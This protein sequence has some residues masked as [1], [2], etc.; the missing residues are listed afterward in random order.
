MLRKVELF[1]E[2]KIEVF[3]WGKTVEG[4]CPSCK[5]WFIITDNNSGWFDI[6]CPCCETELLFVEKKPIKTKKDEEDEPMNNTTETKL[7]S[8]IH[9]GRY[10]WGKETNKGYVFIS[11][12]MAGYPNDN[13]EAFMKAEEWLEGH[14]YDVFNPAR[15][16]AG[17]SREMYLAMDL[18]ALE[19]CKYVVLLDG[20]EKAERCRLELRKAMDLHMPVATLDERYKHEYAFWHDPEDELP[21][22]GRR[23]RSIAKEQRCAR[24]VDISIT[25]AISQPNGRCGGRKIVNGKDPGSTSTIAMKTATTISTSVTKMSAAGTGPTCRRR[26][27]NDHH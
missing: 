2:C 5:E 8:P 3:P 23:S 7:D 21:P 9:S 22:E 20:W 1:T 10:P 13:R 4:Y 6:S 14:G 24:L 17:L 11:G 19:K 26:M 12:P 15:M 18:A 27:R 25:I 16:P